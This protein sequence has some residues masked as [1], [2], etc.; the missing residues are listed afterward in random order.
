MDKQI[1][2][3]VLV[4]LV[5]FSMLGYNEALS[6]GL[7]LKHGRKRA[8]GPLEYKVREKLHY[9]FGCLCQFI[10]IIVHHRILWFSSIRSCELAV[11]WL[12]SFFHLFLLS[13]F[14]LCVLFFLSNN[15]FSSF[16]SFFIF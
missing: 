6:T 4:V 9:L 12:S 7:L 14:L 2:V 15:F 13:F 11:P 10:N 16:L 1:V 3:S 5:L 8:L